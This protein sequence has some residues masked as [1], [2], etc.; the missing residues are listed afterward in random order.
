MSLNF[1]CTQCGKCCRDLKLPLTVPET[2]AWL[3]DGH[4][5]QLLCDAAPAAL[6]SDPADLQ[7]AHRHR[8]SFPAM[9]GSVPTQVVAILAANLAGACPN[10]QADHRC[11]I[12]ERR[13]LV[14]RIYPAEINPFVRLEP[15]NKLCPPEAW[16]AERPLLQLAGRVVD[17]VVRQDIQSSRDADAAATDIKRRLCAALHM[18]CAAVVDEG[19]VVYSPERLRLLAALERAIDGDDPEP[20]ACWRFVSN[21]PGSIEAL[22]Q[23]GALG[24]VVGAGVNASFQYIGFLPEP[25]AAPD[26]VGDDSPI[27]RAWR[28]DG[29]E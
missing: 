7:A 15:A 13:P 11:G 27:T 1:E 6:E 26:R 8:R 24:S 28:S 18:D 4:D 2:L 5:V 20:D 10:L 3:R 14:C 19:F 21:R 25:V 29:G 22:T 23:R 12:Y 9:S 16:A 17:P